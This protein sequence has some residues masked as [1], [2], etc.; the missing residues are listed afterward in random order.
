MWVENICIETVKIIQQISTNFTISSTHTKCTLRS[1][2]HM[3][4]Q[5]LTKSL[6]GTEK[7]S[8]ALTKFYVTQIRFIRIFYRGRHLSER[9]II[10]F[11]G[12]FSANKKFALTFREVFFI[13]LYILRFVC[14]I[15]LHSLR[16][17]AELTRS[18]RSLVRSRL[19]QL[20]KKNRPHSPTMK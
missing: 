16:G 8:T 18:L 17:V 5:F 1:I 14:P 2:V 7:Q 11:L 12:I 9:E 19:S 20:V 3:F 4:W 10:F 13:I 15:F 6:T